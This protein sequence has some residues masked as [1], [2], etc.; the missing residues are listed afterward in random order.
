[1]PESAKSDVLME[2]SC[3]IQLQEDNNSAKSTAE[4]YRELN[5]GTDFLSMIYED[6]EFNYRDAF[7]EN[8]HAGYK[9]ESEH[10]WSH[11]HGHLV[12]NRFSVGRW[13]FTVW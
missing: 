6:D 7:F 5:N 2:K 8:F 10:R 4:L 3:E 13:L 11:D 9:R 12:Q 1:M